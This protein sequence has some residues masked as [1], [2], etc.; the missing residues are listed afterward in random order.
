MNAI[1]AIQVAT[2]I[3]PAVQLIGLPW[4][5]VAR[6]LLCHDLRRNQADDQ[7]DCEGKDDEFVQIPKDR[8][9]VRNLKSIGDAA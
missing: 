3:A 6:A 1:A 8:D 9:K 7:R 5:A 2:M 4:A